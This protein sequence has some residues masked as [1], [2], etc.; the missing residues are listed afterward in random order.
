MKA[1]S[2]LLNRLPLEQREILIAR[3]LYDLSYEQMAEIFG[4]SEQTMRTRCFRARAQLRMLAEQEEQETRRVLQGVMS[5]LVAGFPLESFMQG[6]SGRIALMPPPAVPPS[7]PPAVPPAAASSSGAAHAGFW[8]ATHLAAL[9]LAGGAVIA[10]SVAALVLPRLPML[11]HHRHVR[12]VAAA[13]S[14]S[15]PSLNVPTKPHSPKVSVKQSVP[16]PVLPLPGHPALPE[17]P[18]PQPPDRGVARS[19]RRHPVTRG[20]AGCPGGEHADAL[21]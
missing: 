14:I 1:I 13:L 5:S 6:I 4:S 21:G 20:S 7:V 9:K 16:T 3:Y 12:H 10:L 17:H 11:H 2:S 19:T 15:A 8:T 18:T